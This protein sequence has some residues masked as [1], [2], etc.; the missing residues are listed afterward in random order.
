MDR[1]CKTCR[2]LKPLTDY[3]KRARYA[4]GVLPNCIDCARRRTQELWKGK[5]SAYRKEVRAR[6]AAQKRK[7]TRINNAN[8]LKLF[9]TG[10]VDCS[11]TD[12]R[13]LEFDHVRGQKRFD[14]ALKRTCLTWKKLKVEIDKCDV[15]CANCHKLRTIGRVGSWRVA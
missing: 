12:P 1:L 5:S 3:Y 13:V 10:C 9:T 8:I 7:N 2:E 14:I 6:A 11:T 4:G 15:V